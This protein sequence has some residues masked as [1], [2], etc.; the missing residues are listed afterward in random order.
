MT[1]TKVLYEFESMEAGQRTEGVCI[2]LDAWHALQELCD[3]IEQWRAARQAIAGFLHLA[4]AAD[5][6]EQ[7]YARYEALQ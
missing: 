4:A 1:E 7:A 3:A 5:E 6:V 2:R